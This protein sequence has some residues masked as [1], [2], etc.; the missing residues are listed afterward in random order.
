MNHNAPHTIILVNHP[1][2]RLA[3]PRLSRVLG[4]GV[5]HFPGDYRAGFKSVNQAKLVKR[6]AL[7]VF[8]ETGNTATFLARRI[9]ALNAEA[10]D[11]SGAELEDLNKRLSFLHALAAREGLDLR[12]PVVSTLVESDADE[13]EVSSDEEAPLAT[14][15]PAKV[16]KELNAEEAAEVAKRLLGMTPEARN[17][18]V[19]EV[20]ADFTEESYLAVVHAFN[21]MHKAATEAA[22]E[23]AAAA[24]APAE[25][26]VADEP[27][28]APAEEPVAEASADT[29]S[30]DAADPAV[31]DEPE[32]DA[33]AEAEPVEADA[34]EDDSAPAADPAPVEADEPAADPEAGV[35]DADEAVNP[36]AAEPASA[37][38]GI[39]K[40]TLEKLVPLGLGTVGEIAAATPEQLAEVDSIS[41]DEAIAHIAEAKSR[42][43]A[44]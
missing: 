41:E 1:R 28:D 3:L 38:N 33:P 30:D 15:P 32:A 31:D 21:D 43:G 10:A 24:E 23:A 11:L 9:E 8:F 42:L 2:V 5:F 27:A 25:E 4:P 16:L 19:Q 7:E 17:T 20:K 14:E 40:K 35:E 26:A 37:L 18:S 29:A 36:A 6:G 13:L 44:E 34:A 39:G 22:T 12:A